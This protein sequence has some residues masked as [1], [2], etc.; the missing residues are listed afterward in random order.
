MAVDCRGE[1]TLL[2]PLI[3]WLHLSDIHFGHGSASHGWDQQLVLSCLQTDLTRARA[4]G[5][6]APELILVTGD[7]AFS[8]ATRVR[9]GQAESTEYQAARQW[10]LNVG[11]GLGIGPSRIFAVPGNHDVQRSADQEPAIARLV[12]ELRE[13]RLELDAALANSTWRALLARRQAHY[14]AWA[15][16]FAP[17]CTGETLA[18][19]ER[20]FW[21]YRLELPG[22]LGLRLVGLNT[23]LLCANDADKGRLR[24]G[25]EQLA[26]ALLQPPTGPQECIVVLSHHPFRGHWLADERNADAWI[27]NH[28]H[29]HLSGH[30]HE[31]DS[32]QA[33]SGSGGSFVHVISGAAHGEQL[34]T[35]GAAGHGY[36]V[37]AVFLADGGQ[38]VLRVWPRRWSEKNKTFVEDQDNVPPGKSYSEH[39]LKL[40]A[41]ACEPL[42]EPRSEPGSHAYDIALSFAG[43]DRE[44]VEHCARLLSEAGYR[45]FY[46]LWEQHTLWGK[47]LTAYLDEVYRGAARYCL[48]FISKHYVEK[49]W[50]RHELRSALAR[51]LHSH[52]EYI[53]PVRL[54]DTPLPGVPESVGY[55][56]LRILSVERLVQLLEKK[57]GP[58]ERRRGREQT[59]DDVET[60]L[61]SR[62]APERLRGLMKAIRAKDPRHLTRLLEILRTDEVPMLRE[63]AA[64]ALDELRDLRTRDGFLAALEDSAWDV[65]SRAGWGLVHLG[66]AVREDVLRLAKTSKSPEAREMARLVL[67][68]L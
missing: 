17:A 4:R 61:Q 39:P 67:E 57:L 38:L 46:D 53:L 31:A 7:I 11:Q 20:L 30:V 34:P 55:I 26:R 5:V 14:L 22:G 59:H 62:K 58:A 50:T 27:R 32:E 29:L 51:A 21:T 65:R 19:E 25:T 16:G 3:S 12:E 48:L 23:A 2:K 52:R 45:V 35:G 42:P 18:P 15:A 24:L 1:G 40:T 10:L 47:D 33:H 41:P 37:A 54:D 66:E 64:M 60:L 9:D 28:A 36:N 56:D 63:Q 6:P 44:V 68:R 8:G 49:S 13:G 43:E